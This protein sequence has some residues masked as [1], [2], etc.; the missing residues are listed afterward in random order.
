VE[1]GF[2]SEG[3]LRHCSVQGAAAHDFWPRGRMREGRPRRVAP[4]KAWVPH[5]GLRN[6]QVPRMRHCQGARGVWTPARRGGCGVA[7]WPALRR[8]ATWLGMGVRKHVSSGPLVSAYDH[9]TPAGGGDSEA[10]RRRA[11]AARACGRARM[12]Q[13]SPVRPVQTVK[14]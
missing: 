2:G 13:S 5:L 14:S 7:T 3:R 1:D 9:S 8:G 6:G 10:R 11:V 4:S 12:F